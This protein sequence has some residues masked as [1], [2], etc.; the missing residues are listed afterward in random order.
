MPC[1]QCGAGPELL[2]PA[3]DDPADQRLWC[4]GC[5]KVHKPEPVQRLIEPTERRRADLE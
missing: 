1:P 4:R 2:E 3:T 5:S